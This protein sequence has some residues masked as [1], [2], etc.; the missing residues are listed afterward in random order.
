MFDADTAAAIARAAREAGHDPAAVLAI[1]EVESGG[2]AFALIDG[3]REPLIRFEGHYF[4]R[5]LSR[6]DKARARATG[7]ASPRAGGVAN[8]RGQAG[9]WA[10][11][12]RAAAIDRVAA[13]ESVSWGL[14]QVMGAHWS[15]LGYSSVEAM[16]EEARSGVEGQTRQMLRYVDRAGLGAALARRDWAAFARGYNGPLYA[17]NAYDTRMAAA[18]AR[19]G[20][21]LRPAAPD[22][23]GG[24]NGS[25][26][27]ARSNPVA[28][29]A[30]LR[31]GAQ[32]EAVADLQRRLSALGHALYADGRFGPATEAA[33]KRF[34]TSAGLKS[35][36][37]A[38]PLTMAALQAAD[39]AAPGASSPVRPFSRIL[40]AVD[41]WLGR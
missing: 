7:L 41:A 12:E 25:S 1:A 6:E 40:A 36:G 16:V 37:I 19:H 8:P 28:T 33:L 35:D 39:R 29:P 27:P 30:V 17:R 38:G 24:R 21:R 15:W 4:D 20:A 22:E 23:G 10:L 34:Q 31:R 11:L 32:G 9:R 13:W 26:A 5:R 2:R 14:G 3:R 18:Y